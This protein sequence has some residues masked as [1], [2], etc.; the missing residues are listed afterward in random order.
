M[1]HNAVNPNV[2]VIH[3]D[4]QAGW[5]A[6]DRL[7][8]AVRKALQDCEN[9]WSAISVA[10]YMRKRKIKAADM[11]A[12]IREKDIAVRVFKFD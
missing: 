12:L 8:K 11:V 10:N 1:A 9:N 6:Y 2:R 3:E 4:V 5:R 7:P